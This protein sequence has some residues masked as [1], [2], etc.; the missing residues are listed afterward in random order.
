MATY[1]ADLQGLNQIYKD[2]L[3]RDV[4]KVGL[5]FYGKQLMEGKSLDRIK[6]EIA[7]SEEANRYR[8]AQVAPA[9]VAPAPAAPTQFDKSAE[10]LQGAVNQFTESADYSP[11]Q[12][13]G[14]NYTPAQ[15]SQQNLAPYMNPYTQEVIDRSLADLE[16]ARLSATNNLGF[17]ASQAGAF[18]GSRHGV[19]EGLTNEGYATQAGNLAANLRNQGFGIAQNAALSDVNAQNTALQYGAGQ[20]MLA[21]QLNQNAG[22]QAAN[23]GMG[24]GTGM[25]NAS[26]AGFDQA[27]TV[28]NQMLT[29]GNLQQQMNQLALNNAMGQYNAWA[30][31][32]SY[33]QNLLTGSMPNAVGSTTIGTANAG[34]LP[35]IGWGLSQWG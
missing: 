10:W 23:L 28:N 17:S 32:P 21:Q 15:L 30:G 7:D 33:G 2:V 9:P 26:N 1:G 24:A 5:D 25:I 8:Q 16:R 27:N 35:T 29:M 12:V 34:L 6:A 18:G 31:Y 13:V 22:L 3:G 11:Q 14:V 20:N 4:G 19:A